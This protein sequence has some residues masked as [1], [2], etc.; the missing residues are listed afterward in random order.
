MDPL[1][2]LCV[3]YM[4]EHPLLPAK[5]IDQTEQTIQRKETRV[6]NDSKKNKVSARTHLVL[7]YPSGPEPSTSVICKQ[8]M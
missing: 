1:V 8:Q 7:F 5:E 2:P 3:T 6:V 4:K